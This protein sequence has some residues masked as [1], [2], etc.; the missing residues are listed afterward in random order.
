MADQVPTRSHPGRLTRED[1]R[2]LG[3]AL[4]RVYED[5]V[6]QGVPD[7]FKE[8]LNELERPNGKFDAEMPPRDIGHHKASTE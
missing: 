8:L 2:R 5:T 3:E 4:Q 7:R 6:R 1:Q